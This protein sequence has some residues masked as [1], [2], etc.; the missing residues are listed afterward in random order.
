MHSVDLSDLDINGFSVEEILSQEDLAELRLR[1]NETI[2]SLTKQYLQEDRGCTYNYL[3][4]YHKL[5]KTIPHSSLWSKKNRML[6]LDDT[7]WFENTD[8][9]KELKKRFGECSISDEDGLGRS[10][11]YWRLTRPGKK[12]DVGPLHRDKWFWDLNNNFGHNM[13]GKKRTKVWI[14]IQTEPGLNGL[15]VEKFSHTRTD[16]NYEVRHT[17]TILKPTLSEDVSI[18]E[19]LL[20]P[21]AAGS[22]IIFHDRLLHGGSLNNGVRSRCS[23]EF[24]VIS[25]ID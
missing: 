20:V 19:L 10:N 1:I 13:N 6:N 25:S 12:S 3:A 14:A 16:L 23:I 2:Y 4:N 17:D 5:D 7:K 15:L 8:S 18:N 9:I 21:T 11:F 22:G 24:T